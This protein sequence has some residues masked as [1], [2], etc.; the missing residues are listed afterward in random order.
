MRLLSLLLFATTTL[1]FACGP[2]EDGAEDATLTGGRW[3]LTSALRNGMETQML[4]G[5]YFEFGA[6][7]AL[8]TNL[9]GN[10]APGSYLLEENTLTTSGVVPPLVY[11]IT[12]LNDSTLVLRTE[13][14]TFRFDF[15]LRR[16][17]GLPTI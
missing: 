3:E 2:D 15:S 9:M 17:D 13:L 1:F 8:Q 4:E 12:E 11:E 5:L 16:V 6:E 14:Q 7:G 10:E